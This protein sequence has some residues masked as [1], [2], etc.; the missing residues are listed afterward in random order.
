MDGQ[1][2]NIMCV[3]VLVCVCADIS[4]DWGVVGKVNTGEGGKGSLFLSIYIHTCYILS[5]GIV[6]DI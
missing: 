4:E 6:R 3:C 5:L 2:S 1:A